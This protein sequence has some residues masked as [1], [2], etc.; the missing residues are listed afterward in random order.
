MNNTD[1]LLRAFIVANGFEIKK[2]TDYKERKL[3]KGQASNYF[4]IKHFGYQPTHQLETKAGFGMGQSSYLI[5]DNG[6]YTERLVIPI[7]DYKITKKTD[8]LTVEDIISIMDDND[9]D[10]ADIDMARNWRK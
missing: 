5:D 1:K 9:I 8:K 10:L 7:I 2:V 3:T 4:T 6:M